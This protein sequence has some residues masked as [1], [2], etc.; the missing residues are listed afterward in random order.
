[1]GP[2]E[3]TG[4]DPIH[5]GMLETTYRALENGIIITILHHRKSL[6]AY[7]KTAG[8]PMDK[9][10]GSRTS[11]HIGFFG[12]DYV[13]L[14]TRDPL[15]PSQYSATGVSQSFIANRLSWFFDFKGPSMSVDT[16]CSSS[17]V[18]LDLGCEAILAKGCTM[19][20]TISYPVASLR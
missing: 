15:K 12:S 5:R 3:A 11:V 14:Q 20:F 16:A 7:K 19:V 13:A 9:A 17:L 6:C 4:L 2:A 10:A 18:A 8:I 1:M